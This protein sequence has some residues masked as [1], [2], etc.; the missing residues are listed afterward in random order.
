MNTLG[1]EMM[2][3]W[4]KIEPTQNCYRFYA[5]SLASDLFN[6]YVVSCEW[7]RI[8]AKKCRRKVVIFNSL[9]EAMTRIKYEESLR[10]KHQYQPA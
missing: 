6:A 8:G 7:G 9:D 10:L 4:T 3:T 5:I 1:A 2:S